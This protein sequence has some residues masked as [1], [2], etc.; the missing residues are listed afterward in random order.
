MLWCSI[1]HKI[2]NLNR[3]IGNYVDDVPPP[4]TIELHRS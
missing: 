2:H 3:D 1:E 4:E